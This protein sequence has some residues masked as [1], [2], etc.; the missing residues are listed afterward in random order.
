MLF[1]YGLTIC[2]LQDLR[3]MNKLKTEQQQVYNKIKN[4]MEK[5]RF[6]KWRTTVLTLLLPLNDF[7]KIGTLERRIR[8]LMNGKEFD[9]ICVIEPV[10]IKEGFDPFRPKL[11]SNRY[12]QNSNKFLP[13]YHAHLIVK[14]EPESLRDLKV[15]WQK[16]VRN[17]N[18]VLFRCEAQKKTT[19]E[20]VNYLT[21]YYEE[22]RDSQPHF[23]MELN[24]Y[25]EFSIPKDNKLEDESELIPTKH[26]L[27]NEVHYYQTYIYLIYRVINTMV[28]STSKRKIQIPKEYSAPSKLLTF[29]LL[30]KL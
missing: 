3:F 6:E 30:W 2:K 12:Y 11:Y 16:I 15:E 20:L 22:K 29:M 24:S 19:R 13:I 28:K 26:S 4:A 5:H 25:Y 21:K 14:A 23:F 7:A 27:L 10:I 18:S 9:Y 8:R 17:K 1:L